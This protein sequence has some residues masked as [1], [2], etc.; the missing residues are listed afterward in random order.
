MP[1]SGPQKP[2]SE[3]EALESAL[4]RAQGG[5]A[6]VLP[7]AMRGHLDAI[8]AASENNRGVL[9]VVATLLLKKSVLPKQ[10]IRLHRAGM[11]GGFSGRGLDSRLVTP[12]LKRNNFPAMQSGSGWLTRSL[13]QDAPYDGKYPGR[14]KPPSLRAAFLG[15]IDEVQSGRADAGDALA[16]LLAGLISRRDA[17]AGIR[18]HRPINLP[19]AEIIA[20]LAAHFASPERGAARLPTLAIYAAYQRLTTEALRYE[21]CKLEPLESHTAADEKT[22]LLG[23]VQVNGAD[24]RPMEAVEIKHNIP[25]TAALVRDCYAK[26]KASPVRTFYLLSTSD[27]P[28]DQPEIDR[29]VSGIRRN[30]G[31]EVI[32]NGLTPSLKYYLRLLKDAGAFVDAYVTLLENDPAINYALKK[33]WNQ[34]GGES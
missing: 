16:F 14:I 5:V 1:A 25:L 6:P 23:D 20:R 18:L 32:V 31:C 2:D 15:A 27:R 9:A 8:L 30:H 33:A 7:P 24:G 11:P 17:S 3:Q 13:E 21:G 12:F 34:L 29:E 22:G 28:V 19:I 26:F 10:D 4:A